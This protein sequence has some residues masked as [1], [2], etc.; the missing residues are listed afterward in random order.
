MNV[1]GSEVSLLI[2]DGQPDTIVGVQF[3]TSPKSG[4]AREVRDLRF[5]TS[6]LSQRLGISEGNTWKL[7]E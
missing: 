2:K 7:P 1:D 3:T 6:A 5:F 4:I